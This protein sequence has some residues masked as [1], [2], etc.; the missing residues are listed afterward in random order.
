MPIMIVISIIAT[1]RL[2]KTDLENISAF[3]TIEV[4]N[5]IPQDGGA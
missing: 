1:L 4:H 3:D 5:L 2:R